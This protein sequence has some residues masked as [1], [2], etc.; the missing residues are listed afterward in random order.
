LGGS[1]LANVTGAGEASW[2]QAYEPSRG[3]DIPPVLIV[4][5]LCPFNFFFMLLLKNEEGSFLAVYTKIRDDN[6][7]AYL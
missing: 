3:M 6:I 4:Y 7:E 2:S 1:N 5:T